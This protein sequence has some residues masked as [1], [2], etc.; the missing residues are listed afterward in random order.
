M[1]PVQ[2]PGGTLQGDSPPSGIYALVRQ[3]GGRA[4]ASDRGN[5]ADFS[6]I[7]PYRMMHTDGSAENQLDRWCMHECAG[8]YQRNPL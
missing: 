4:G 1:R 5:I 3:R 8:Q 2:P 7:D 6:V